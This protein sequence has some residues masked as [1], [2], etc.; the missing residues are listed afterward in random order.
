MAASSVLSN[1]GDFRPLRMVETARILT[2]YRYTKV[3]PIPP[4]LVA[5]F[6][7]NTMNRPAIQAPLLEP[8]RASIGKHALPGLCGIS[9]DQICLPEH[10]AVG[11]R[12]LTGPRIVLSDTH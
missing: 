3:A 7:A 1:A 8:N 5:T 2:E 9:R 6:P 12:V 11:S 10:V 4:T